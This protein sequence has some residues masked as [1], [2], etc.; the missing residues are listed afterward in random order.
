MH[1]YLSKFVVLSICLAYMPLSS[2]TIIMEGNRIIYPASAREKTLQFS[3]P[4]AIP[5]IV[6]VWADINNPKSKPE[7]ADAP[8]IATPQL[9]KINPKQGQVVRLMFNNKV[10]LPKD[11]ESIFYFNFLQIPALSTSQKEQNKLVLL[12]TSRLK[13]FYR[14]DGLNIS[15]ENISNSI[16]FEYDNNNTLKVINDSPYYATFDKVELLDVKK[17]KVAEVKNPSMVSPKAQDSWL[18][19]NKTKA[20]ATIINYSI[21]NDFGVSVSYHYTL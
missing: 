1:R 20:N 19:Q 11:R 8:F 5:Y 10:V 4:D 7:T 6:Q 21:I 15:P 16:R 18:I 13:L 2:A 14:P 9:F 3:N 17:Q 12:V